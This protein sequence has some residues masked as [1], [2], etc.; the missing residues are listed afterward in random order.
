M[1]LAEWLSANRSSVD[2]AI[3]EVGREITLADGYTVQSD[4]TRAI[5]DYT[6]AAGACSL[7][8]GQLQCQHLQAVERY[9]AW[10]HSAFKNDLAEGPR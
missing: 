6:A 7:C 3:I 9:V 8:P 5:I 2:P 1:T 4:G 10:L